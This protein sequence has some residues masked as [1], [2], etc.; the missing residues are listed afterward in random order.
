MRSLTTFLS[1]VAV[2][3]LAS[4]RAAETPTGQAEQLFKTEADDLRNASSGR[5]QG[6]YFASMLGLVFPL[7]QRYAAQ[8]SPLEDQCVTF[9]SPRWTLQRPPRPEDAHSLRLESGMIKYCS[10]AA[11]QDEVG[12]MKTPAD[13]QLV[14]G[15]LSISIWSS[16]EK[17]ATVYA[18]NGREALWIS[19]PNPYLWGA[20]M[21]AATSAASHSQ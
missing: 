4:V 15:S 2:L 14:R 12:R 8:L 9:I 3:V 1:L 6:C 21:E 5:C 16:N 20:M 18:S 17:R 10:V 11:L 19:D 13:K 7:P